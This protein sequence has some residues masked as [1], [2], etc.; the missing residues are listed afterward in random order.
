[1][2]T[3]IFSDVHLADAEVIDPRRPLWKAFKQSKHFVD[4][5]VAKLLAWL[6]ADSAEPLEIVLNGDIFDFDAVCVLP[7]P[8]PSPIHWLQRLRGLG[9]EEWMSVFKME[10]IIADH[11]VWFGALRDAVSAGNRLVFVIGNHDL[12][13]HW[14][15]VQ[16]CIRQALGVALDDNASVVFCEWFYLSGGDTFVTHGHQYDPYCV[17]QDPVH[18]LISVAGKPRVRMPF[19]DLA[20]RYMINGMGYFNPHATANYIMS[21]PEY[22]RFFLKYMVRTQPLLIWTWLWG[23]AVTLVITF[24]EFLRPAMRDPLTVED[25]VA[26]I[27]QRAQA[28]PAVVRQL[29]AMD[30]PPACT[31]PLMI[32]QEL[33]LDRGFLFLLVVYA[34]VEIVLAVNVI[35]PVSIWWSLVPFAL[36]FPLFLAYSFRV[37]PQTFAEP[38]LTPERAELIQRITGAR[39]AVMGHT[40]IPEVTTVGPL[41]FCNAGFWSPAFQE[42]ECRTRLGAQTFARVRPGADGLRDVELWEWPVGGDSASPVEFA[43]QVKVSPPVPAA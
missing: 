25:K 43:L 34:A 35:L 3:V 13:L 11:P 4:G 5:D 21:G 7:D 37:K 16:G 18:P 32:I 42:P 38:L 36:L 27:A 41:T 15:R 10:R 29:A 39:L 8:P 22:V 24:L 12:E 33:W 17:N 6:R 19:G 40:H 14:Q 20:N 2:Q 9:T 31:N 28:T 1:M 30:V 26:T 23:A